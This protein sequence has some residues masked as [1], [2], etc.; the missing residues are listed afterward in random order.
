[1]CRIVNVDDALNQ[2]KFHFPWLTSLLALG[3]IFAYCGENGQSAGDLV[4]LGASYAPYISKGQYW[5]LVSSLFLHASLLHLMGN[6]IYLFQIGWLAEIRFGR[7]KFLWVYFL[8]GIGGEIVGLYFHPVNIAVGASGALMGLAGAIAIDLL[9]PNKSRF[10]QMQLTL[11]LGAALL[12]IWP[13]QVSPAT[14]FAAHLGGFLTGAFLISGEFTVHSVLRR[15]FCFNGFRA[16][17]TI[18]ILVFFVACISLP[19][20][21]IFDLRLE[22]VALK[23]NTQQAN[24][25]IISMAKK[26]PS[27]INYPLMANIFKKNILN[28]WLDFSLKVRAA[29]GRPIS[30]ADSAT[31][32]EMVRAADYVTITNRANYI[33]LKQSAG[34][35][36]MNEKVNQG[37]VLS[38]DF[39][40]R[41]RDE[42]LPEVR[43]E[44]ENLERLMASALS[45]SDLEGVQKI[46]LASKSWE[47]DLIEKISKSSLYVNGYVSSH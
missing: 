42:F 26:E 13:F 33:L 24:Q 3:L 19:E 46:L 36:E 11:L 21:Y 35:T 8:S 18:L 39:D 28:P 27:R 1:M 31:M 6:L 25:E 29:S 7:L 4:R 20:N 34:F 2:K 38:T 44:M 12:A 40:R 43:A 16:S 30:P 5:R 37:L 17:C 15:R 32:A 47:R 41:L 45:A 14:D 9:L 22:Y 23:K 10:S